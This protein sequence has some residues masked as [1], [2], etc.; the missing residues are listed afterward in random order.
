MKEILSILMVLYGTMI[1]IY[2]IMGLTKPKQE[3]QKEIQ[4]TVSLMTSMLG[5]QF[6][7][8]KKVVSRIFLFQFFLL[9][10]YTLISLWLIYDYSVIRFIALLLMVVQVTEFIV[11]LVNIN[12][13]KFQV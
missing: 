9:F 8:K 3:K 7:K 1:G 6:N 13:R 10:G 12:K 4:L 2:L 11:K 5:N